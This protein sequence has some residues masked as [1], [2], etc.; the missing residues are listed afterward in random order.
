MPDLSKARSPLKGDI[1]SCCER[2]ISTQRRDDRWQPMADGREA[3]IGSQCCGTGNAGKGE[4]ELAMDPICA[5]LVLPVR[6][7]F[8]T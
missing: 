5:W 1:A 7:T 4:A 3:V 6:T 2:D 8:V